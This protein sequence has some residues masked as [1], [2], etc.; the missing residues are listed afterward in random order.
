VR[1]L[2]TAAP[3]VVICTRDRVRSTTFYRDVLGLELVREDRFAA[4]FRLGSCALR[5]SAVPDF[6]PH[7]HTILGFIVPDVPAVVRTLR[8]AGV[9]FDFYSALQQDEL[10]VWTSPD[11][12]LRVA[13][14]KDPDGNVLSVTDAS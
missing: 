14:F 8:D 1:T 3:A 4:V 5:I 11:G 2:R 7:E 10:G 9:V 13:W 12:A 6:T